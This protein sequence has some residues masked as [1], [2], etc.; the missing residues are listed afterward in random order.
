MEYLNVG[1][2]HVTEPFCRFGEDQIE[3]WF[4]E[5]YEHD[6]VKWLTTQHIQQ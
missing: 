5:I 4:K 3:T 6:D 2:E 1:G